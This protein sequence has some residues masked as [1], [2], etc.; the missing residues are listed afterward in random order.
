MF[1]ATLAGVAT[2]ALAVIPVAALGTAAHAAPIT[3][4]TADIDTL[5]PQGVQAF[6]HRAQ[7]AARKFCRDA[8]AGQRGL[9]ARAHCMNAVQAEIAEKYEARNV[10]LAAQRQ[11]NTLASR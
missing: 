5:S 2:L 6:H 3:I 8:T 7:A 9:S 1:K 11:A 10:A 4:Q